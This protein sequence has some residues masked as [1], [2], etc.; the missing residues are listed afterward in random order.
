MP[1]ISTKA[2]AALGTQ[3][4]GRGWHLQQERMRG[5]RVQRS[6]VLLAQRGQLPGVHALHKLLQL[7]ADKACGYLPMA[8]WQPQTL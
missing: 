3:F 6:A 1:A 7:A 2:Q 8:V 5:L 4:I